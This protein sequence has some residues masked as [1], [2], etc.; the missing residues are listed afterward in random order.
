[1]QVIMLVALHRQP[2]QQVLNGKQGAMISLRLGEWGHS[3]NHQ[4][5]KTNLLIK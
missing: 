4:L 5:I 2:P 1:M 3:P